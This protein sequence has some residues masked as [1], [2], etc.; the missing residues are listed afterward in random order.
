MTIRDKNGNLLFEAEAD[1]LLAGDLDGCDLT[2]AEMSGMDFGGGMLMANTVLSH[3]NLSRAS[4]YWCGLIEVD[5]SYADLER[6]CLRGTNL[7][8]C[9]FRFSNLRQADFG[10]SNLGG[11]TAI[12]G[13]DFSGADLT[14]ASFDSAIYDKQTRFPEGFCHA[15]HRMTL[16]DANGRE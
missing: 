11:A 3:A 1:D 6:A 5:L 14:G 2:A 15:E 8:D 13:C 7:V 4:F 10:P 9:D 12:S 16:R